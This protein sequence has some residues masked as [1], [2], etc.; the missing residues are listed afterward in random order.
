MCRVSFASD[1]LLSIDGISESEVDKN[2]VWAAETAVFLSSDL[3]FERRVFPAFSN[4]RMYSLPVYEE[5]ENDRLFRFYR[6]DGVR[7]THNYWALRRV[8][9][10]RR[11]KS[12]SGWITRIWKMKPKA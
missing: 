4:A 9:G 8:K 3:L 11:K 10:Q 2:I 1:R 7:T 5:V 12:R 6:R